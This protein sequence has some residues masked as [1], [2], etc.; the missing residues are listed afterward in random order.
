MSRFALSAV[1]LALGL[2]CGPIWADVAWAERRV[3]LVV[4]NSAYQ[5]AP[6]LPNPGRDAKAI[7]AKLQKA[8]FDVVSAQYDMGNLQFKRAIR[9]FED[10][11]A[12]SDIAVVYFAGHGIEIHG[13]NYLVPVDAKL[14][15]DRDAEDE[16]ISLDRLTESVDGATRLRLVILDAC[17]DNPFAHT[18]K[19]QRSAALRG[20]TP[21]LGAVE[22]SSINT[23]VAYAAKAGSAAEDGESEHSPFTASLLENLFTPGLDI[24][25][26]FGRVRDEVLKR[27]GQRQEPF[28]YGSLG[29][30]NIALVPAPQEQ[31]V[32]ATA[33]DLA[34]EKSDYSLVEKI[35]T[36]GAWQVFLTQHP[37]GFFA[38]LARQQIA[39][40]E[41]A[42]R[43][44]SPATP[45]VPAVAVEPVKTPA[46]PVPP[47]EEQR[48]WEKIK[49]SSDAAKFRAF[50]KRYPTSVLANVAQQH[51]E[52]IERAAQE[53]AA[54]VKA[55]QEAAQRAQ[56]EQAA[57]AKTER[58][59]AQRAEAQ[60]Q[61]QLAEAKRQADEAARQK[62]EQEAAL[63]RAQGAAKAAEE[64]RQK[65]EREAELKR[66]EEE[67]Q[68][69][70]AA[71]QQ[72]DAEAARQSAEQKPA[73]ARAQEEAKAAEKARQLAERQAEL[74]RKEEARQM[75]LAEAA[76]AKQ[77][78]ACKNEEDRLTSLQATGKKAS[79]HLKQLQQGLT[80]EKLR[81]L[82]IAALDRVNALPDVNTPAQVRS[83]QQE[84]SRLGCFAGAAD[85]S[86]SAP[87]KAA[88]QRYQ[89]QHGTP[90]SV[91]DITDDFVSELKQQS[92]R[93]CPLAC[94][95][96]KV[97][98]GEQCVAA[99][100]PNAVVG[101]GKEKA[102]TTT[103]EEDASAA[104][105]RAKIEEE[106]SSRPH[107][108]KQESK[109]VP[110][111]R[112]EATAYHGGGGG[113]GGGHSSATIGVGF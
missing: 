65:A 85:G 102:T 92:A 47:I 59:A 76:R 67:L 26:A 51:A 80:C 57:K 36:K 2:L 15:S 35:G 66:R 44:A 7:A 75:A 100:N 93:V 74:K 81:P 4:G 95:D 82:V 25:L 73:L 96:G 56:E 13:I 43:G 16:A 39:K 3:A 77:E 70:E 50:I 49:D 12:N 9:Q 62:A 86:L 54:K 110:R 87:T 64:A 30:G 109:P 29:G 31:P 19:H 21:G 27:T 22:P 105:R 99:Q 84:L 11:A 72:A 10:E 48:A 71:K 113:G 23:L 88:I 106:K 79:D 61:A 91:V 6:F 112:Q 103:K 24:R 108:A 32:L 28:V 34:G 17:R 20:I 90:A 55:D 107:R 69:A 33:S 8:G 111:I 38:G 14:A 5:N 104:R 89:S 101:H 1:T 18:M 52:A 37:E 94:P 40:L 97:A 42:V 60:R 58:E 45:D 78:V 63:A 98:D 41:P 68:L 46:A 53:Q 83:A